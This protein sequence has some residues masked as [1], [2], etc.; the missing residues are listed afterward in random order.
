MARSVLITDIAHFVGA[1]AA[2]RLIADGCAVYGTDESFGDAA[3]RKA[4]EEKAPGVKTLIETDPEKAVAEV[5]AAEGKLD[6]LVNND[7]FPA[8]R[9]TIDT[10]ADDDL[11]AGFEALVFKCFRVTRAAAKHMKARKEGRIV[12]MSSAAPMN[13]LANY[14]MY[15]AARGAANSLA[16]ALSKELA[17]FNVSVNAVAANFVS[18]PDYFPPELM[19]DETKAAK[20][21]KNIPL[22]RL[23]APEEAAALVSYLAGEESGFVTGQVIGFS[24]GWA[25]AR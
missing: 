12:I 25:N 20:I 13:G 15:C 16:V 1:P 6:V 22:N 3:A 10:F 23:G 17:P 19:A 24:G 5:I 18:N 2:R 9:A 11:E 14:S 21:L 4:F 7:S 8:I